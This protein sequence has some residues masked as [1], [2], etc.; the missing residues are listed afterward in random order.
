MQWLQDPSQRNV[1]NLNNARREARRHFKNKNKSYLKAKIGELATN[2]EIKYI[3]D[4]YGGINGF[5][6]YPANAENRVSS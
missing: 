2:S 1:D 5:N 3:R 4:L 6:P